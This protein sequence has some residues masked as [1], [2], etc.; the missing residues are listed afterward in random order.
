MS[1]R[2][3]R[4]RLDNKKIM[5]VLLGG[6][7]NAYSVALAFR[8]AFGVCSHAFVRYKCGATENSAFIKTHICSGLDNTRAMVAE[9]FNFALQNPESDLYLIPCTDNYLEIVDEAKSELS[10]YYN[11]LIPES[12][13]RKKLTDKSLFMKEMEREGIEF[14]RFVLFSEKE[15]IT[16][17]KMSEIDYPAVIKPTISAEYW[18]HPF[19]KMKKVYF[20]KNK[21]EAFDTI[22]KIFASGYGEGVILQ[23]KISGEG[24]Q[25]V[26][27]T[28]SD[29]NGSV[30]R[31]ALGE[32]VLEETGDTS[33]G[34]HAAI[35]TAPLDEI[36][37]KLIKYLNK[38]KYVG[39]AN[40]DIISDGNKKYV[41]EM[42]AR[43]GRSSD[44]LRC[45]GINI[46]RLIV[47]AVKNKSIEPNFDYREIYW[48]YPPHKLVMEYSDSKKLRDAQSLHAKGRS[49]SPYANSYEGVKRSIYVAL[50]NYRLKDTFRKNSEKRENS[51]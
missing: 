33:Q 20:P 1:Q 39:F 43:Q 23:E 34:N 18:K 4:N 50:H 36:S 14:P 3:K 38:I 47:D 49:F 37:K 42:N 8:E 22:Y 17:K 32:V 51:L 40:F 35:I 41:L 2:G 11:I 15:V 6:D 5:P 26:L 13:M 27:T 28:F 7:L 12:E 46:A 29:K 10:K 44:Y 16:D 48:H 9:L 30:V 45:A 24:T 21:V 31:A 25:F 19:K